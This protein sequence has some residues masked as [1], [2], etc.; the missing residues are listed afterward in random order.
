MEHRPSDPIDQQGDHRHQWGN[1]QDT[2]L[3]PQY[4]SHAHE[5]AELIGPLTR[6]IKKLKTILKTTIVG[7]DGEAGKGIANR[8]ESGVA[9]IGW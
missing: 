5:L 4:Q 2:Q 6:T 9:L 7:G 8:D 3:A 1:R